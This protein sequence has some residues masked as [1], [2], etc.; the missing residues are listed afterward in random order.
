MTLPKPG[1]S[2]ASAGRRAAVA[3]LGIGRRE[4]GGGDEREEAHLETTPFSPR[5]TSA[6]TF[7]STNGRRR[8]PGAA[9]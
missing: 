2:S 4:H 7:A 6:A 9:R 3:A 8:P 1:A 5:E